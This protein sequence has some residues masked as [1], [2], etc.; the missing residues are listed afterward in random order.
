MTFFHPAHWGGSLLQVLLI[1]L[2]LFWMVGAYNR[3]MRLRQAVGQAWAQIDDCLPR[4][5]AAL[6][7][8]LAAVRGALADQES[9]S[10]SALM[11]ALERERQAA[12][13]VRPRP[14][15]PVLVQAWATCERELV[16]PLARLHALVEQRAELDESDGVRPAR[17]QLAEL[18][19]RLNFARQTYNEA[20]NAYNSAQA[21]WPTRLL[22]PLFRLR[23]AVRL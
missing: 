14:F 13:A 9:G 16:S 15:D 7:L 17:E 11:V 19:L 4:R 20:A 8:L 21:D 1:L 23:P 18:A 12:L 2:L 6:A 3:L 22:V 5:A 10:L